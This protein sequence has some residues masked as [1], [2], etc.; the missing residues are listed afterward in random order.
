ME[1]YIDDFIDKIRNDD[2]ILELSTFAE[3][4]RLEFVKRDRFG[5]QDHRLKGFKIF[6]GKRGKRMRGIISN[7][8]PQ[9]ALHYPY[10][11]LPLLW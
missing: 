1:E 8:E 2:R 3:Q 6:K 7:P 5:P 10:L 9:P 4:Y 11:R